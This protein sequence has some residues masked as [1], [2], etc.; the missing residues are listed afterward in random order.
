[1]DILSIIINTISIVGMLVV[2]TIIAVSSDNR[3]KF[4]FA[5]TIYVSSMWLFFQYIVQMFSLDGT[6]GLWLIQF[7]SAISFVIAFLFFGFSRSYINKAVSKWLYWLASLFFFIELILNMSGFM[8]QEA[9]GESAG[10]VINRI[11]FLYQV[12][13]II[14]GIIFVVALAELLKATFY[15]KLKKDKTR[16]HLLIFGILQAVVILV[17]LNIFFSMASVLQALVPVSL[18]VMSIMVGLAIIKYQL[19]DIKS[20]V[21]RTAAYILS[22]IT[23]SAVYFGLAYLTSAILYNGNLDQS[24]S[25]SP[26][27]VFLALLLA[28][29]FQPIKHFFDKV[30][31]R[32]FY[33]DNYNADDFFARLNRSLSVTTDLRGLLERVAYEIGHT[34]KSEQALFFIYTDNGHYISAGTL[35]HKQLPKYDAAKI[36]E[37][38]GDSHDVIVASL[39]ETDDSIRRLMVSHRIEAILPLIKS[40]KKIGFLCLGDHLTSGYTNRDIRALNTISDELIIA[41][42]NALAVEEIRELNATL[43]QK[44]ANATKELRASNTVLMQLDRVKDEFIGM[45]SHQLRTPLTSVKGYIS[46]IMEGDA[47]K[48]TNPQRKLLNEAFMSSERMVHL[49]NDFLNV[50]RIQTGKF[51]I[52][53]SPVNL[54]KL[55]NEEI[56]SLRPNATARGLKFTYKPPKNFPIL[57]IDE[58]KM[59]QVVMNFADNAIYYSSENSKIAVS[60][61]VDK[62]EVLFTVKDSGIGV[63]IKER[64]HLFSKFYRASNARVRRPDGTGVGIYLAKKVIDALDGKIVFESVEGKGST[65]GFRL[66]ISTPPK[67]L[68]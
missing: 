31:N 13:I 29:V 25:I 19:F 42:Q 6:I 27:N 22:L 11:T 37:Y 53:K 60:L 52:D 38:C 28:F 50:S 4:F 15:V 1:M 63:P 32:F 65:F 8:V 35:H 49:I 9:W 16:N 41:I 66:P 12:Y 67:K 36:G 18:L 26:I 46:M 33:K 62:N 20:A 14:V 45:A 3:S 48:I 10:V 44:V 2:A 55:V 57:Y 7:T 51:I 39:L 17:L 58:G 23:L 56:D 59:R 64:E 61:S 47:G 5:A 54:S 21:I 43:Q 34:L 68:L 24:I 40:D 30:T